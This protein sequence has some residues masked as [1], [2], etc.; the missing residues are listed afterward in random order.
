MPTMSSGNRQPLLIMSGWEGLKRVYVLS[1][2]ST[3]ILVPGIKV[4]NTFV[5][6][7]NDGK[8]ITSC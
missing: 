7:L 5:V 4:I 8:S 1:L 6:C 2:P 3:L